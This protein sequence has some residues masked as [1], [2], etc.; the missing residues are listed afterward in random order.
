MHIGASGL[1]FGFAAYLIARGAYSRRVLHLAAGLI[2]IVVY[3]STLLFG[4]VP[5][6]GRVVAGPRVRRGRRRGRGVAA[7][8][9]AASG[10]EVVQRVERGDR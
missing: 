2:V 3:G 10:S 4:L 8:P 7:G 5:T 9:L 6:P 1:V